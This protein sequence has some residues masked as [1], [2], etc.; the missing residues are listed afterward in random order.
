[1]GTNPKAEAIASNT[2]GSSAEPPSTDARV[3]RS[4]GTSR[5]SPAIAPRLSAARPAT[6]SSTVK[7]CPSSQFRRSNRPFVAC[8]TGSNR[9][10][11][12]KSSV[13]GMARGYDRWHFGLARVSLNRC[14]GRCGSTRR[15]PD[16]AP[17][18]NGFRAPTRHRRPGDRRKMLRELVGRPERIASPDTNNVGTSIL[19]KWSRRRLSGL[20]G[21]CSG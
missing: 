1:M 13:D 9:P 8:S 11:A 2:A 21:G 18:V 15:S 5:R 14:R 20:P 4:P 17:W 19:S 12:M 16:P 6:I 10:A 7:P 3:R